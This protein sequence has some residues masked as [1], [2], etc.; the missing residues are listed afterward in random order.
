MPTIFQ[1]VFAIKKE[2]LHL[3]DRAT[4][5]HEGS[6]HLALVFHLGTKIYSLRVFGLWDS[7]LF[8]IT[9]LPKMELVS[10]KSYL[11]AFNLANIEQL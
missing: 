7:L 4:V 5:V 3:C 11:S 8:R 2:I 10:S 6:G 1:F 9:E